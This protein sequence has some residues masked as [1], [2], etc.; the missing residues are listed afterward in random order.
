MVCLSKKH[1]F[2]PIEYEKSVRKPTLINHR[3]GYLFKTPSV[4]SMVPAEVIVFGTSLPLV[5]IAFRYS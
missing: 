5:A 2:E 3:L 1:F 4:I